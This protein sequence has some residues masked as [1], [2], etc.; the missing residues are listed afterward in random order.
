[1]G[2]DNTV[3]FTANANQFF[4]SD[5]TTTNFNNSGERVISCAFFNDAEKMSNINTRCI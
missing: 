5:G 2:L 4:A 1:M 3:A